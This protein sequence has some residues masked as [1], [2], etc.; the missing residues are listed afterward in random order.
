MNSEANPQFF[1]DLLETRIKNHLS[2]DQY[3]TAEEIDRQLAA[4]IHN[5]EYDGVDSV[6][7]ILDGLEAK[8]RAESRINPHFHQKEYRLF[9]LI[10][11]PEG[12]EI[13]DNKAI[14]RA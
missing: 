1:H 13:Q 9:P 4:D 7:R 6:I 2:G 14:L 12:V 8:K 11:L 3:I 10:L 5:P